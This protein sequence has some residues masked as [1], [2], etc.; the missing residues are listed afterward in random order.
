MDARALAEL[1][2]LGR[3]DEALAASA[4][5]LLELEAVVAR[6]RARAE[7]IDR[8][9]ETYAGEQARLAATIDAAASGVERR[10]EELT[11]AEGE[12][13][14]AR[15]EDDRERAEKAVARAV[16]HL[17]LA[18]SGIVRVRSEHEAFER[19]AGELPA[20]LT[21]LEEDARGIAAAAHLPEPSPSAGP[22][23]LAEWASRSHAELF[24]ARSQIDT[25]RERISIEA[26][27]LASMLLGEATYGS[28]VAQALQR[29]RARA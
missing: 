9:F 14:T 3:R 26:N 2:R 7:A 17:G 28:T 5:E 20:E 25:Q 19:D 27:E 24:V 22:R 1:D 29:V 11:T 8:F 6:I 23:N 13:A 12:L 4:A 18:E 10:R 16:D 21:T 15:A